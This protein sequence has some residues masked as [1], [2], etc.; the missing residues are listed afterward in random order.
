MPWTDTNATESHFRAESGKIIGK[1]RRGYD[2]VSKK[3]WPKWECLIHTPRLALVGGKADREA[4]KRL[5]EQAIWNRSRK[6]SK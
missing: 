2:Y 3:P 5:V 4:A 1:V 6:A